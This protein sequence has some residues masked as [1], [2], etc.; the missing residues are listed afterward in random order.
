MIPER[1]GKNSCQRYFEDQRRAGSKKNTD[2]NKVGGFLWHRL[3]TAEDAEDAE[4]N[5]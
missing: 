4:K 3:F 2:K 1:Y 5:Y